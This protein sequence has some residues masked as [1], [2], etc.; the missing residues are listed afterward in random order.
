M[1]LLRK[2]GLTAVWTSWDSAGEI[3]HLVAELFV[4]A[5]GSFIDGGTHQV[6]QHLLVLAR[7]NFRLN[8]HVHHLLLAIHLH[9]DHAAAGRSL[10]GHG[11]DL[12]LQ[13]FLHLPEPRKHLLDS[14][15]FHQVSS[16]RCFT[17]AIFPPKRCSIDFTIGS[18]SNC[19]R[20][21][22]VAK[23]AREADAAAAATASSLAQTRTARPSTLLEALRTFSSAS[24]PSSISANARLSDEK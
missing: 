4:N 3:L 15:D 2:C 23:L 21:S 19:A 1:D 8:A 20:N 18:R 6:L 22:C 7:K 24:R 17:S 14:I 12:A 5:P 10:H 16:G 11:I 9:G 13:V